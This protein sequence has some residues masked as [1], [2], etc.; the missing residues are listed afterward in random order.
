MNVAVG[1]RK[2]EAEEEEEG[3][4]QEEV[5]KVFITDLSACVMRGE[6]GFEDAVEMDRFCLECWLH[7]DV[8]AEEE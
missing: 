1:F 4:D 2:E 7:E 3:Y 5:R 8:Y 6:D